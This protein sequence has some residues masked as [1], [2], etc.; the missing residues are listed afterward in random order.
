M[1][2][3]DRQKFLAGLIYAM[4]RRWGLMAVTFVA[5]FLMS[6][7]AGYLI[8]PTWEAE[9]LLYAE[10][11]PE[12]P[13][14]PFTTTGPPST[15]AS[16]AENLATMLGG[17]GIAL[18]MVKQFKLDERTR[19][20]A[21]Q[22]PTFRDWAKVTIVNTIMSP[23]YF[24]Q[25]IGLL[26]PSQVD[27]ADKAVEDFR[28]GFT[29]WEDIQALEDSDVVSLKI[30]GETPQL[31][32]DIA[33]A[34]V[35]RARERLAESTA[36]AG[37]ETR[38]ATRKEMDKA[39]TRYAEE[40]AKL[41]AFQEKIGGVTLDQQAQLETSKLQDLISDA[42]KMEGEID[43]LKRKL[44]EARQKPELIG[45]VNSETVSQS[46]VVETLRSSLHSDEAKLAVM[47]TE[48]TPD[49]P[50]V[51]NL[52]QEIASLRESLR[53][54]IENVERGLVSDLAR[55]RSEIADQEKSLLALP[56]Q[57][58]MLAELTLSVDTYR[59]M[60]QQ[61]LQSS[62]EADVIS[63]SGLASLDFKVLDDA[64]VSPLH[65]SDWPSWIIILLV[66]VGMGACA[67]VGVAIFVEYWRDPVKG[68]GDLRPFEIDVLGVLPYVPAPSRRR[69]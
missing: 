59:Q 27:W 16:P 42:S 13:A 32:T 23:Y 52:K 56:A 24:L 22:P 12:P 37:R 36:R 44:E 20:K 26:P 25:W 53:T 46:T 54:E 67:A 10:A 63:R 38:D 17:K 4:F 29:A 64:Y 48:R 45:T 3:T 49:H 43:V 58:L 2:L 51:I 14:A 1:D 35:A 34:M 30:N 61:L 8:T 7:F 21:Q 11:P 50:D 33:N 19:L 18:D 15:Q 9:V 31:A 55:T 41:Q 65:T 57:Q 68:A 60:Y 28:E 66:A 6:V 40:Q 39:K 47:I 69:R 5:V 62:E